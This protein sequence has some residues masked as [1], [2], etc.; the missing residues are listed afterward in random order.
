MARLRHMYDAMDHDDLH[1]TANHAPILNSQEARQGVVSG[2]VMA[3][4]AASLAL[5]V[6]AMVI[7][8][9]ATA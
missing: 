1:E 6:V 2:R 7:L 3:I 4:L 8:L 5:C 9:A